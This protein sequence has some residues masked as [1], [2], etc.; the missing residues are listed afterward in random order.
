MYVYVC[1]SIE[2]DSSWC[3][4][5]RIRFCFKSLHVNYVYRSI[6]FVSSEDPVV[7]VIRLRIIY[8]AVVD[9]FFYWYFT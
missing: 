7:N 6:H 1:V 9:G 5:R 2:K 8:F 4:I 3:Q